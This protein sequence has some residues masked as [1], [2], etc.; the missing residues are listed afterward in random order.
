MKK[1]YMIRLERW[2]RWMLPPQEADDVLADYR[3]IVGTPPRSDD[4]LLRDLGK[5][6]DVI[7]P[8]IP[9]KAYRVWLAVFAIMAVCVLMLG[10]S[11]TAIGFPIWLLFFNV[12]AEYPCGPILAVL[13]AVTALVWFRRQEQKKDRLPKAILILLVV[14]LAYIGGI[15]LFCWANA[16][17]YEGFLAMW[18]TMRPLIGPNNAVPRLMYLCELAMIY[19]C[20]LIALAGVLGLVKARMDDRRWTAVYV[21]ALTAILMALLVLHLATNLMVSENAGELA[22]RML[23]RCS[24]TAAIGLVGAGVAL[25]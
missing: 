25:C 13:G 7:R 21:L 19:T 8:L 9:S 24:V 1:D 12:W 4:E 22:G 11:P 5:P 10:I 3:D 23:I 16:Q 14:F 15:L 20:P 18:G 17:D 2:A 6:R